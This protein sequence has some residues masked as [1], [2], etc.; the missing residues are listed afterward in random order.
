MSSLGEQYKQQQELK[1]D[2]KPSIFSTRNVLI[3]IGGLVSLMVLIYLISLTGISFPKSDEQKYND[4]LQHVHDGVL[5]YSTGYSPKVVTY[6]EDGGAKTANMRLGKR[7]TYAMN[8]L[9]T[10]KAVLLSDLSNGVITTL[11]SPETNPSGGKAVGHTPSWEDVDG[12]AQRKLEDDVLYYE[13][14][15]PEPVIDHWNTVTVIVDGASYIVDSRDWFVNLDRMLASKF[16]D[17]IPLSASS[18]NCAQCTGSY[19]YYLDENLEVKSLKY[20][21]PT[22]DSNGYQGVYP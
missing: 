22:I 11:G 2:Q 10:A 6:M 12:D 14:A 20:T 19:S 9:G 16:V 21:A 15:S 4:D 1:G 18:D 17:Y 13:G 5:L 3:S 7:P 8:N